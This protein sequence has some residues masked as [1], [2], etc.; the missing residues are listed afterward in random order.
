LHFCCLPQFSSH[1]QPAEQEE[2]KFTFTQKLHESERESE[3]KECK[4]SG[5]KFLISHQHSM[6]TAR[7]EIESG[8]KSTSKEAFSTVFN[9]NSA[10]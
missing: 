9:L 8:D 6:L 7:T 4:L 10:D 1:T 5:N 2:E 3:E